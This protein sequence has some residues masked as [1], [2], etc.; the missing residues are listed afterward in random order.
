MSEHIESTPWVNIPKSI[1]K[2]VH[3]ICSYLAMFPPNIPNYFIQHY[4]KEGDTVF[5]PF[6]GRG[7]TVTE[8]SYLNRIA[9]GSDLN[10]LALILSRAKVDVPSETLI[11][12]RID[13]LENL[14]RTCPERSIVSEDPNIK[15]IFSR[16]TLKELLFLQ[17][18][19]DW[20]NSNIDNYITAML[21]GIIHGGSKNYLSIT[22]PNTFSMS[23]NY[24]KNYIAEHGL[25]KEYKNVFKC[26]KNKLKNCYS[27][28]KLQGSIFEQDA[29]KMD[30]ME[31]NSVDLIITSPPYLN[32]IK[33]GQYNWIRLWFIKENAKEVDKTLFTS[34]SLVKYIDF[35]QDFLKQ[36]KKVLKRN[37]KIVLVIGDVHEIN[38]A[39]EVWERSAEPIGLIKNYMIIDNIAASTKT[40]KIWNERKGKSTKLD[41]ILVLSVD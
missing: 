23:P 31:S 30:K 14:F 8:A 38:L 5:D 39:E 33:Y 41:R 34:Q 10:P 40:T 26:L 22:M 37:G 9:I 1:R 36:A 29:S 7:T 15:M 20:K 27:K 17:E 3:G 12:D 25:K 6:S 24:I 16:N 13:N 18:K 21:L 19:L 28:P 32:V 4:T 2:N 11:Q 35:M